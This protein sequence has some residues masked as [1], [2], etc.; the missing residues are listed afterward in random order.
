MKFP[1]VVVRANVDAQSDGEDKHP[2][3]SRHTT[4]LIGQQRAKGVFLA[5]F[6]LN[7]L[8]PSVGFWRGLRRGRIAHGLAN[9]PF[10]ISLAL[11]FGYN[12]VPIT[13]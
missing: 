11:L 9:R 6:F 5:K 8:E 12:P 10:H 3:H 7:L 2:R 1:H 13:P 4:P